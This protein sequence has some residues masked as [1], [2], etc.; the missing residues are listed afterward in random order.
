M[1][2]FYRQ[3]IDLNNETYIKKDK[4]WLQ[5]NEEIENDCPI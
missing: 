3:R 4:V 1:I 5:V 2:D